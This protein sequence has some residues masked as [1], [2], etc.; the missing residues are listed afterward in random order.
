MESRCAAASKAMRR[1]VYAFYDHAFSF[2]AFINKYP[3]LAG[4]LTD[5][6][7]GSLFIDFDPLFEAV[8]EFAKVPR[9]ARHGLP[10]VGAR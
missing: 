1:L 5:C 2:R 6:L 8:A 10:L 9:A 7:M 4:D 3:H